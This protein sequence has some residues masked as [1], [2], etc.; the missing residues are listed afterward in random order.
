M[1]ITKKML[2]LS[3]AHMPSSEPDFG[4]VRV[5]QHDTGFIVFVTELSH[6][7]IPSWMSPIIEIPHW[8]NPIIEYANAQE[9]ILINFDRDADVEDMFKTFDW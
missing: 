2:D 1:D 5:S 4:T 7:E 6:P 9:C 8:L 3:T